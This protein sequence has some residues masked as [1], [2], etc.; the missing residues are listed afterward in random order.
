MR[1]K[2][3]YL[4][5]RFIWSDDDADGRAPAPTAAEA[6]GVR[7]SSIMDAMREAV[8]VNFGEHGDALAYSSMQG[9]RGG[10]ASRTGRAR[11]ACG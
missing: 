2:N 5:V 10:G 9:T 3:R 6:S 11:T 8:R 1:F 4:L 7:E